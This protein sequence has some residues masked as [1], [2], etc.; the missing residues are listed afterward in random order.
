MHFYGWKKG[1]KTGM[2]YL[3]SQAAAD[4]IKF[5]VDAELLRAQ[6]KKD[7][8]TKQADGGQADHKGS[9]Q[10]DHKGSGQADHK[11]A[12][13]NRADEKAN[14]SAVQKDII[15]PIA[16]NSST[17][18]SST[19]GSGSTLSSLT[20]AAPVTAAALVTT[21]PSVP[22][23]AIAITSA[24][25]PITAAPPPLARANSVS[26]SEKE[27]TSPAAASSSSDSD[28]KVIVNISLPDEK[29][30]VIPTPPPLFSLAQLKRQQ[31]QRLAA[32]LEHNA[33]ACD[34]C[35]S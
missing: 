5:T 2:Y 25:I 14:Q 22:Q 31:K 19:G 23:L 12:L 3:R 13:T 27:L 17:S 9:G 1:L 8:L 10:A 28:T 32:L 30:S 34:S 6:V 15:S 11:G 21:A 35:G 4:A 18:T 24:T 7:T 26:D 20:A 33:P 16:P 29:K